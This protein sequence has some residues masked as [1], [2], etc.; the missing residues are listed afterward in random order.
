MSTFF[1]FTDSQGKILVDTFPQGLSYL[2]KTALSKSQLIDIEL[3]GIILR[4]RLGKASNDKGQVIALSSEQ[5]HVGR[6]KVFNKLL[7]LNLLLVDSVELISNAIK[8]T[9][10]IHTKELIHNLTSLNSYNIQNLYSLIPQNV[11]AKNIN[12][13][14]NVVRG[15]VAEKPNVTS[16]LLLDA[17][18]NNTAMKVEFSIFNKLLDP[19]PSI[20]R[21]DQDIR[22]VVISIIQIFHID[23]VDKQIT[24]TLDACDRVIALDYESI[25]V[26]LFF[27]M[28]NALKYGL[29]GSTLKIRFEDDEGCFCIVFD[30]ISIQIQKDE[31]D[32]IC[33]LGYRGEF[34]K[35]VDN[36]GMG[37]GMNRALKTLKLNDAHLKI[38]PKIDNYSRKK[39]KIIYEHNLFKVMFRG[40]QKW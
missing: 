30:M 3:E 36:N 27:I 18:R 11:L 5:K 22:K 25:T 19:Y 21:I 40:Q 7:Q 28:E 15:I 24:P 2:Q 32:K 20:Q 1:C 17:I 13:Q 26:S 35:L 12:D 34:A 16:R 33:E 8:V 4:A 23:L 9:H 31:V 14:I 29:N 39:G 10:N 6:L 38:E 37:I